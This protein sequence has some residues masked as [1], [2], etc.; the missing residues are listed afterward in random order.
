MQGY[1]LVLLDEAKL[2]VQGSHPRGGVCSLRV[3]TRQPSFMRG[4]IFF[5]VLA[6]FCTKL[7]ASSDLSLFAGW[8]SGGSLGQETG[9]IDFRNFNVLGLRHEKYFAA[10]GFENNLAYLT[11]P[12]VAEGISGDAGIV[13]T[14]NFV[15]NALLL[16]QRRSS[17]LVWACY[18]NSV[19][20]SGI[21]A[22]NSWLTSDSGSRQRKSWGKQACALISDGLS[23]MTC[24]VKICTTLSFL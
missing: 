7:A 23:S 18:A 3:S 10:F 4:A 19:I 2:A 11:A 16:G 8:T 15:L 1:G 14:T 24:S 9:K 17:R 22:Q 13:Y 20:P 5:W 21:V 6:F 12:V